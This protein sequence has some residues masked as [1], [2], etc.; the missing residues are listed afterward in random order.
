MAQVG[1]SAPMV[2][3][4]ESRSVLRAK[5]QEKK[6]KVAEVHTYLIKMFTC[7]T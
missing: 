2:V 6:G 7:L 1:S 5:D 4:E 3:L